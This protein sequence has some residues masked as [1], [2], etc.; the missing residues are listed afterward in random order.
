M[1]P[2]T[3]WGAAGQKPDRSRSCSQSLPELA[4]NLKP[5]QQDNTFVLM[6]S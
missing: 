6:A 3:G 4:Q 1:R 2:F 5:E